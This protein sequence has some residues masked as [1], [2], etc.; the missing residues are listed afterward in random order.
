MLNTR[1][2]QEGNTEPVIVDEHSKVVFNLAL[3]VAGHSTTVLLY[4]ESGTG[5][6]VLARFIHEVSGRAKGPFIAI[7]CAAIPENMLEAT[8]FGYEKGAFT[9]AYSMMAG[10]FEQ[11]QEG[12]LLL[13][14]ISEM[15]LSLQAKLLRVIQEKEIERLGAKKKIKLD[16][17][18]IAATNKTLKQEVKEGRFREDLYYRVNVFPI[19]IPPLRIR[20]QDILPLA[21]RFIQLYA[22]AQNRPSLSEEAKNSLLNCPWQGN[23]RELENVIQRALIIADGAGEITSNNLFWDGMEEAC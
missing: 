12:T 3:R 17:R 6:E 5:K 21:E 23:V 11:A 19:L 13:D 8:L 2:S 16:I 4:G 9:G 18:I 15:P 22:V 14:E 10:K 20:K 1:D 7:N